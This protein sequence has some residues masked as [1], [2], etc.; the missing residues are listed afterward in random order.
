MAQKA[1]EVQS[2]IFQKDRW[3]VERAKAWLDEHD[4]RSD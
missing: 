4:F 2:V 3:T 1:T